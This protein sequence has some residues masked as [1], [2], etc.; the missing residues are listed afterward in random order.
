M[1]YNS[2]SELVG[3]TPLIK[4]KKITEGCK[5]DI[6]V[7]MESFNPSGSVKDRAALHMIERAEEEGKINKDTLIIEATS[8]NTG[9]AL[10][11]IAAA[12]GYRLVLYIP[13]TMSV[14]KMNMIKALGAQVVT[15]PGV[16]G[17][18]KAF[19]E[20]EKR[21]E[22]EKNAYM[23]HQITNPD[24]PGAHIRTTAREIW[25][26]MEG[27]IDYFVAASGT[28]GTISGTAEG[29]KGFSDSIKIICVEPY[30]SPVLSG[31]KRGPHKIQGVG[32]GF[33]PITT[34][35]EIFDEIITVKDEEALETSRK[36]ARE[37]G[38]LVGISTGA[39]VW[40]SMQVAQRVEN[41][42]IVVISA[43]G[44]ERYLHTELFD[45]KYK[46]TFVS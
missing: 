40:A 39:A 45:S 26:D 3:N 6:Y 31:G 19:L 18:K 32:P 42:K 34:N 29:L 41:K 7:K 37:E 35:V 13:D 2:I 1:I 27:N 44:G 12:K 14:D 43:D 22:Q 4:L 36:L 9:I 46:G 21:Y 15:T 5:S 20:A 8:G 38:L 17:M 30:G 11:T 23:P 28:G 16:F 10:A 25:N 33:I 24:N